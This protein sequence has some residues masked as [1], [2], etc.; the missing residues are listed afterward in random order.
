[1]TNAVKTR[2]WINLALIAGIGVLALI[3]WLNPGTAPP[4]STPLGTLA[5]ADVRSIYIRV[6]A[7]PPVMLERRGADW[8]LVEPIDVAANT[9]R[10]N[11]ILNLLTT[12]AVARYNAGELNLGEF[13]L[14]PPEAIVHFNEVEYDFG[15]ADPLNHKRYV[16]HDGALYLIED[17]V[18]PLLNTNLGALVSNK[19]VPAAGMLTALEFEDFM[20]TRAGNGGWNPSPDMPGLSAD[21]LQ[22]WV[23]EWL[24]ARAILVQY[25]PL[26]NPGNGRFVTLRFESGDNIQYRVV[27][28][29]DEP[30]LY[31]A[32]PGLRYS[33]GRDLFNA[34][35]TR[36][37]PGT[38]DP[39]SEPIIQAHTD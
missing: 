4:P 25:G 12:H 26:S 17:F 16:L 11:A 33:L 9:S 1:M 39:G 13:G 28:D 35:V 31:R 29:G 36:P 18:Y 37:R 22:A 32:E 8:Q 3:L 10:V 27:D 14:L 21:D 2:L 34:L 20:L 5:K 38:E 19:L 6:G 7:R 30:A 24:N 15:A 23:N